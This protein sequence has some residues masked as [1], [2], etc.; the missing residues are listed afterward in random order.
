MT[1]DIKFDLTLDDVKAYVSC[2]HTRYPKLKRSQKLISLVQIVA[3][4]LV[5]ALSFLLM[6]MV[7]DDSSVRTIGIFM[8]ILGLWFIVFGAFYPKY[9]RWSIYRT[10][11]RVYSEKPQ[12]VLG[13]HEL[14]ISPAAISDKTGVGQ[15][16]VSWNGIDWFAST[17]KYLF[18]LVRGTFVFMIPARAFSSKEAFDRFVQTA[19]GYYQAATPKT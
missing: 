7:R 1:T 15:N 12:R 11:A 16:N 18:L 5:L 3:G 9:S 10:L 6:A 14:S 17:D 8:I 4:V 19:K 2:L 13:L